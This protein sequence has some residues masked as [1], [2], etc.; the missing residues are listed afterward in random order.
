MSGTKGHSGAKPGERRGGRK[1]GTPNKWT[2][3]LRGFFAGHCQAASQFIVD[4]MNNEDEP[5]ELR[6]RAALTIMD[7]GDGKPARLCG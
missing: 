5:T 1:K 3:S 2:G 6:L 7:R 4:T